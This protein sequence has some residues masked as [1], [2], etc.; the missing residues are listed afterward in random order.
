MIVITDRMYDMSHMSPVNGR[1]ATHLLVVQQLENPIGRERKSC[2]DWPVALPIMD[3]TGRLRPKGVPFS[4]WR[5][6]KGK[7]FQEMKYRK[8]LGKLI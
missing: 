7:G 1:D 4:G 8:G 2:V 5:Y 6:M 3:Y